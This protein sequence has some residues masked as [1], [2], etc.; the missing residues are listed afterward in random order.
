M[1]VKN[2]HKMTN[3][4]KCNKD[5]LCGECDELINQNKKFLQI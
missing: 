4:N 2:P 1:G 3:Y 5:I